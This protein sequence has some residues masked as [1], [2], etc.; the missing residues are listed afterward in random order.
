MARPKRHH[1]VHGARPDP[2]GAAHPSIAGDLVWGAA[3]ISAE[4]GVDERKGFYLLGR[5]LIPARKVG[6]LWVAS[7]RELRAALCG[8]AAA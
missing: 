3:A 7:R 1:Q 2:E 6:A 4:I 8:D 5:K